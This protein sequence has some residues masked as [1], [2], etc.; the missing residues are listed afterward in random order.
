[1][2]TSSF[3]LKRF[4]ASRFLGA[5]SDQFLLFV[6]PL[7]IFKSTGDVKYSGLAFVIEWLPRIL[8]FP[9]AGFFVDRMKARHLF[10]GVEFGR[11]VVLAIALALIA[12]G[13]RPFI[14][15]AAMM[16]VLSIAYILNFVGTEAVLP[17]NLDASELPK[18][19]SM[20]QAVDQTTMVL[21]PA[22][23]AIVSVWGGLNPIL[24]AGACMFG[25]SSL[26]LLG[27][28]TRPVE[29]SDQQFSFAALK[30]SNRTALKVLMENKVLFHL[31]A[32]TWVVNLIYG[33]ALVVSASV[34]L[35]VFALPESHFGIL[36]T[37]AAIT[38]LAA[39]AAVPGLAKKYG[40]SM[41]GVVCFWAMILSG[42]VLALSGRFEIYVI[43][44]AA[45]MAFDGGFSVYIRTVRSQIIPQEHM[46]KTTGLIGLMNMCSIPMSAAAVALLSAYFS[47][48]GIFGIIFA[49]AAVLGIALV[50]FG[51][52]TFGYRTWLP[53]APAALTPG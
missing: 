39:F 9:L 42:L 22:L 12:G 51:R 1:M 4:V 18:A 24:I 6:V 7:A 28:Q 43:G 34:V 38:S 36:Q 5:L 27:L 44:Y 53:S 14:V 16:A 23:A 25:A 21:G 26:L 8:F 48:F 32:L 15:L 13:A 33:A 19:H 11:A 2:T 17:R 41:L 52:S 30:E 50:W 20:L 29:K 45:L 46:G 47:P 31:S 3:G 10:F 37:G 35:K 40:L 49:I